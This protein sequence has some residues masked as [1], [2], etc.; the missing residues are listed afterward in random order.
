MYRASV[1]LRTHDQAVTDFNDPYSHWSAPDFQYR[2]D[3]ANSSLVDF[4]YLPG[5]PNDNGGIRGRDIYLTRWASMLTTRS[6]VFTAYIALMDENGNYIHRCQLTLDR[7]ECF[8]EN[9]SEALRRPI[10]PKILIR[11]DGGYMD[12]TK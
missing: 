10:L 5:T 3:T 1:P 12:D 11:Q 2:K 6:D 4:V 9:P 7:T 8:A